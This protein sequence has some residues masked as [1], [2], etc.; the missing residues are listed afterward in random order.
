[1]EIIAKKISKKS[2]FKLLLSGF[3]VSIFIFCVL[4]GVAALFGM[5]MVQINGV[6]RYGFEGLVYGFLM[7]P[8]FAVVG[9]T[10]IWCMM[11]FGL[12]ITSFFK[13]LNLSFKETKDVSDSVV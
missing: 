11:A 3:G 12:W 1:M 8:V 10:F 5:S 2:L 7:G 4:C 13:P 9:S 6:H